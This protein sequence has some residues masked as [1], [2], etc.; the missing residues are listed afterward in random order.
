MSFY[1]LL[2]PTDKRDNDDVASGDV[3]K[4]NDQ[5]LEHEQSLCPHPHDSHQSEV[6][7]EHRDCHTA[8]KHFSPIDA[9]RKH[10]QHAQ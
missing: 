4:D 3:D 2:T 9:H 5:L 6:V 8:L 10:H 7:D 1:F